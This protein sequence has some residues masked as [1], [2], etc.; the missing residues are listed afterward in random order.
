MNLDLLD[1]NL[2][3]VAK[4]CSGKSHLIKYL[5][6]SY[7]DKFKQIFVICPTERINHHYMELTT[8]EHIYDEW[9][10][11]W[12]ENLIKV[13]TK[14]NANK[15]K[16]EMERCLVILDDISL[17][18]DFHHSKALKKLIGR[19]RH[20]GLTLIST[21]QSL[22]LLS[23][24]QRQNADYVFVGQCSSGSLAILDAEFR[25]KLSRNE[26]IDLYNKTTLNYQFLVINQN[27]SKT[28]DL[29]EIYGSIRVPGDV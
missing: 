6:Q 9:E 8:E 11:E 3:F 29:N 20:F 24:L 10:E 27:S 28:S 26:F 12:A 19:S 5:V 22:T 13:M 25:T 4:R 7:H 23:P 2:I 14:Q 21:A 18:A 15:S 1:K 17:D 16:D